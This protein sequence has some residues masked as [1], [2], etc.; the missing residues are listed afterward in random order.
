MK[1]FREQ[2]MVNCQY[3]CVDVLFL[4]FDGQLQRNVLSVTVY[5]FKNFN[6]LKL[7]SFKVT[8]ILSQ[9]ASQLTFD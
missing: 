5:M 1:Y 7:N 9:S 4:T 6:T 3:L 2:S 8:N